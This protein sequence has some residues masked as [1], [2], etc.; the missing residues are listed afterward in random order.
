MNACMHQHHYQINNSTTTPTTTLFNGL[1]TA[2]QAQQIGN[3]GI[4]PSENL[5]GEHGMNT[6]KL[7][8]NGIGQFVPQHITFTIDKTQYG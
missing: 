4:K 2:Y 3:S 7:T 5:F 1:I 8:T 6:I